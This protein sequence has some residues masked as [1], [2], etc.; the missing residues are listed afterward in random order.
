MQR[1]HKQRHSGKIL[2]FLRKIEPTFAATMNDPRNFGIA[3]SFFMSGQASGFDMTT[4][5]GLAAYQEQYNQ[6]VRDDPSAS[7]LPLQGMQGM[8]M[9]LNPFAGGVPEGVPPEFVALMSQ[10][11]G[12]GPVPGLEHLPTDREELVSAIAQHLV[13]EGLVTLENMEDSGLED[14]NDDKP[15]GLLSFS[16]QLQQDF[17][18]QAAESQDLALSEE[19]IALLQ[20]LRI[21]P[22]TPGTI[23]Q[24]FDRL[25]ERIG[26]DGI[27]VSNT[28]QQLNLNILKELNALLSQP[29]Q[30][31]LKRPQQK[32]YPNLYGLYLLLRVT[33]LTQIHQAGK[34][35]K[36]VVNPDLYAAWQTLNPTEKYFTLLEAWLIRGDLELLGEG[37]NPLNEGSRVPKTWTNLSKQPKT[38]QNYSEQDRLN[39]WPG[40]HNLALMQMF[41]WVELVCPRPDA[42]KGWRVK[43]VKPTPIG[44]AIAT[45][46]LNAYYDQEFQWASESD[47][48][49]PWGDFQPY[50]Q[51]YFPEWRQN[52]PALQSPAHQ[53]GTYIFKVSLGKIWRRLSIS[54]ES[55]LEALGDLIRE[56]VDFDS[57]HLDLFSFKDAM[58]RTVEIHHPY[59][60]WRD[61]KA[62]NEVL[63]GDLPL[64]PGMAM[65]YL[66]DFGDCWE[67]NVQL[68]EIQPGKPKRGSNKILERHGEAP[69][70]YPNWDEDE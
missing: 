54:S 33:G 63:I 3:K 20:D 17:L 34:T 28:R 13:R 11:L 52:L 14:E 62:S 1:E 18:R 39:Y 15:L 24:D 38:Y 57:D 50:F 60:D 59:N 19:A 53:T 29:I 55:T 4:P 58:G 32:S 67:F 44:D 46:A 5:E 25:L 23:V 8:P 6:Q 21:T 48:T 40:F 37:R 41:G 65:T 49:L 64:Q 16:S 7:I 10:Q 26:A 47:F 56:S 61:S 35:P 45:V 42:G 31:D 9:A 43:Q 51:P 69:E 70:Q 27:P 36:L 22:T 30:I 12:L 2:T 66:F 68:E